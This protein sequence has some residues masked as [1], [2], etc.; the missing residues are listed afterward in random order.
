MRTG[1]EKSRNTVTVRMAQILG[2]DKIIAVARR[3]GIYDQV[4][5]N[6]SLV[7]GAGETTLLRLTNAYGMIDNGGKRIR[8][9]LI[10]RIDDRHGTTIFRRD[11][12]ACKGCLLAEADSVDLDARPPMPDDDREQIIDP[13][14]AYQMTSMLNGVTI[15]GTAARAWADLKKT[16]AGKT[17]TTNDSNDTWFIGYSP[18]LVAGI[19]VG[20][21]KP[22]TMGKKETG[23]SVALPAFID[24]MKEALKDAPNTPF[25]VPRGVQLVKVSL[26]TGQPVTGSETDARVI[27]EAFITGGPIFIPGI[28][29]PYK[30]PAP[31]STASLPSVAAQ[32]QKTVG[33]DGEMLQGPQTSQDAQGEDPAPLSAPPVVGTGALY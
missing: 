29:G 26:Q 1:L 8:P 13:R 23:S 6:F 17:G 2:I 4:P 21:D 7:L 33:P 20:Y 24:F 27:D 28:S 15:R 16:V 12:R 11:T 30:E 32:P 3:C 9:S 14:I 10:E 25:R 31:R 22:R 18:D 5:R 19:Y